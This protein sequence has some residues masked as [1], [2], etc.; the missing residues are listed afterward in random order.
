MNSCGPLNMDEQRQSDQLE[1][2]YSSSVW[3][4]DVTLKTCPKQLPCNTHHSTFKVEGTGDITRGF[5][6]SGGSEVIVVSINEI[7]TTRLGFFYI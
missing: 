1:P 4:R 2:I 3:I 6:I 5:F 7:L